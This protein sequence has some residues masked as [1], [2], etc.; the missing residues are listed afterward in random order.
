ME[1]WLRWLLILGAIPL[2]WTGIKLILRGFRRAAILW[3]T[4]EKA[5]KLLLYEL[6]PNEGHSLKD[7]INQAVTISGEALRVTT[8]NQRAI[9]MHMVDHHGESNEGI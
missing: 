6:V 4:L 5:I 2:A 1:D 7:K 9:E 8:E 3:V